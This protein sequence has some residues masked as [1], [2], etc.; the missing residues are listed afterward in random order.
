MKNY[1]VKVKDAFPGMPFYHLENSGVYMGGGTY[2]TEIKF[3]KY[4]N[5]QNP[6]TSGPIEI[7][8]LDKKQSDFK[9]VHYANE[10]DYFY[11]LGEWENVTI[12]KRLWWRIRNLFLKLSNN[13]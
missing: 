5:P 3:K 8:L 12:L 10:D 1:K 9:G 13:G 7:H 6:T 2:I 11:P 4:Y